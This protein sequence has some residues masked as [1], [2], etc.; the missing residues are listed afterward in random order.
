M[1]VLESLSSSFTTWDKII[2]ILIVHMKNLSILIKSYHLFFLYL[3]I[4]IHPIKSSPVIQPWFFCFMTSNFNQVLPIEEFNKKYSWW[5]E[6]IT[7]I[8]LILSSHWWELRSIQWHSWSSKS[9]LE[10]LIH[11]LILLYW[12][13]ARKS[14]FSTQYQ[15]IQISQHPKTHKC[16][17]K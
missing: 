10:R 1:R 3:I 4:I 6:E 17:K 2:I 13:F 15:L 16:L 12:V 14:F 5:E 7:L 11:I 9:P 8:I